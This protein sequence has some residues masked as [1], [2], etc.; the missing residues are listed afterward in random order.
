MGFLSSGVAAEGIAWAVAERLLTD[1][2]IGGRSALFA[3]VM[4]F[5]GAQL[6][7][8]GILGEYVGASTANRSGGRSISSGSGSASRR[9]AIRRAPVPAP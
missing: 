7:A 1:T 8:I 2:W 9:R 5:G 4:F 3:A 6:A